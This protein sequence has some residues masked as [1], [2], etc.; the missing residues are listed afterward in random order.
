VSEAAGPE[1]PRGSPAGRWQLGQMTSALR[2][3]WHLD[4]ITNSLRGTW[5]LGRMIRIAVAVT[6]FFSVLAVI[7]GA[8]A[9]AGL[10][11]ARS[12][13]V[14]RLERCPEYR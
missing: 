6:A 2:G 4:R 3:P 7:I 14:D 10:S 5:P 8:L 11:D 13:V 9:I 12:R 1:R